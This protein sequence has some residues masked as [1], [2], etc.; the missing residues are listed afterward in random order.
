MG[1]LLNWVIKKCKTKSLY[2][3]R[4]V[5]STCTNMIIIDSIH[6]KP[7]DMPG[8]WFCYPPIY[9]VSQKNAVHFSSH[10]AIIVVF[11]LLEK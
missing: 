11:F 3:Q 2:K 7:V 10:F 6:T 8:L 5:T 1:N 9:P 4:Q